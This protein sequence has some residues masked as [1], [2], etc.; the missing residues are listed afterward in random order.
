[1][2]ILYKKILIII[3]SVIGSYFI[4]NKFTKLFL[5]KKLLN[6]SQS[7]IYVEFYAMVIIPPVIGLV[8]FFLFYYL[9]TKRF[10]K[11]V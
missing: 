3:T 7:D 9:L 4:T 6:E 1:M 2:P 8:L 5:V 10:V 11:S